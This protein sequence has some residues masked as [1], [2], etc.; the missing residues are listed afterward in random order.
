MPIYGKKN[1]HHPQII[2]GCWLVGVVL[3]K[4]YYV[5]EITS[6]VATPKFEFTFKSIE[7]V[8]RHIDKLTVLVAEGST[9]EE[10][11]MV[12]LNRL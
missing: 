9:S 6:M 12:F 7:E 10:Y 1:K 11:F 4:T 2:L 5:A 8:A 3:I